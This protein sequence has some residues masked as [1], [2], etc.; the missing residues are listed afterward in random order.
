MAEDSPTPVIHQLETHVVN[1]IA[2]GE[3]IHRPS[4]ALKEMIENS[5][6]AGSTSITVTCKD[7]GLKML[8]IQDNGHGIREAD[9]PILCERFTTSK[10]SNYED[11]AKLDTFGFRGEALASIS[12][13]A[14]VTV[15]T[16][17]SGQQCAFK[18]HY[19]DG[20]LVSQKPGESPAPRP[21]AG[22][23]G[24]QIVV[25]DLFYNV[26]SRR[27]AFKSGAEEYN[28]TLDVVTRYALHFKDV[29]FGCKKLGD[30]SLDV[31]TRPAA[32]RKDSVANLFGRKLA[33]ELLSI[34]TTHTELG[35]GLEAL[36]SNPNWN[37]KKGTFVL[38]INNRLVDSASIKKAIDD[39]RCSAHARTCAR[40][41]AR[42][43]ACGTRIRTHSQSHSHRHM[44]ARTCSRA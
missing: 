17:T 7:G 5:L 40:Q 20:N 6:D 13:V 8:Q 39:V 41:H 23:R 2:A 12:H 25:E 38:F 9:L 35:C 29:S 28:R 31:H 42:A 36:I 18:A 10:I 32:D 1:K 30:G 27:K 21:C 34:S 11:L 14:R 4:S 26:P 16:M 24:T 22:V 43:R 15:T 33:S 44:C 37:Q 19:T 3:V